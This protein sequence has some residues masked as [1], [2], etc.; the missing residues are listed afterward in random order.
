MSAV[1]IASRSSTDA[2][3]VYWRRSDVAS[4]LVRHAFTLSMGRNASKYRLRLV[5]RT[6]E[7][8][9][10]GIRAAGAALV[11]VDDITTRAERGDFQ[12]RVADEL[13]GGLARAA[14]KIDD[15]IVFAPRAGRLRGR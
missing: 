14:G 11:G 9:Q 13:R 4:S 7:L 6:V 3:V 15:R 2:L 5:G 8:A 1:R 10:E 12:R